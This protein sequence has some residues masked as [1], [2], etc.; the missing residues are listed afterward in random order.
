MTALS[1]RDIDAFLA[2]QNGQAFLRGIAAR[3]SSNDPNLIHGDKPGQGRIRTYDMHPWEDLSPQDFRVIPT[4]EGPKRGTAS[5]L[6]QIVYQSYDRTKKF[7]DPRYPMFAPEN[8]ARMA[9][10]LALETGQFSPDFRPLTTP[11][12][13]E[14]IREVFAAYDPDSTP[15]AGPVA[16][17]ASMAGIPN[18]GPRMAPTPVPG[19]LRDPTDIAQQDQLATL[20]GQTNVDMSDAQNRLGTFLAQDFAP[21]APPPPAFGEGNLAMAIMRALG[22]ETAVQSDRQ[23]MMRSSDQITAVVGENLRQQGLLQLRRQNVVGAQANLDADMAKDKA[24]AR[25]EEIK[26]RMANAQTTEQVG[27]AARQLEVQQ[28]IDSRSERDFRDWYADATAVDPA[29]GQ[30]GSVA[31]AIGP[32][33]SAVSGAMEEFAKNPMDESVDAGVIAAAEAALLNLRG[34]FISWK[35]SDLGR[36]VYEDQARTIQDQLERTL[37]NLANARA[38]YTPPPPTPSGLE[39]VWDSLKEAADQKF[40]N[41]KDEQMLQSLEGAL[42]EIDRIGNEIGYAAQHAINTVRGAAP[43][44]R[45]TVDKWLRQNVDEGDAGKVVNALRVSSANER[46]G[47]SIGKLKRG[48]QLRRNEAEFLQK[49]ILEN[50]MALEVVRAAEIPDSTLAGA[51]N[52]HG[53]ANPASGQ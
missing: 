39:R 44:L 43:T 5:G 12:A 23:A 21:T 47:R 49:F 46:L 24:T 2:S 17:G 48:T 20:L 29:T 11:E 4:P 16:E 18:L 31:Q 27:L 50:P 15:P 14:R 1:H 22:G 37:T 6:Y 19:P 13:T 3:E 32:F 33:A 36:Q 35:D 9:A 34:Q 25:R 40:P 45:E 53:L 28:K 10:A 7:A 26:S 30:A 52:Q 42:G 41:E 38:N 51:F 8:Q